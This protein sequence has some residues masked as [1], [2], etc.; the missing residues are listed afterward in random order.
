MPKT[1]LTLD[2]TAWMGNQK[3]LGEWKYLNHGRI[4]FMPFQS[5]HAPHFLKMKFFEGAQEVLLSSLPRK[6]SDYREGQT[7]VYIVDFLNKNGSIAFRL[8]YQDAASTGQWGWLPESM[9]KEHPIDVSIFCVAGFGQVEDYPE[10]VAIHLKPKFV[11]L[12]HWEDFFVPASFDQKEVK[13]LRATD[14]PS[15]ID[16]L[17]KVLPSRSRW[18]LPK[19]G[20]W[21]RYP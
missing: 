6:V 16:R 21:V 10:N 11:I 13:A 18:V 17:S 9:I 14:I 15:F 3:T 7:L 19:P 4:R 2:V 20:S 12:S 8:Y 1:A 5:S